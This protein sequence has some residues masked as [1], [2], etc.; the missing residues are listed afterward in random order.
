MFWKPSDNQ[1]CGSQ[2]HVHDKKRNT[3]G[4]F[5]FQGYIDIFFFVIQGVVMAECVR[6]GQ[7][8]NQH[9]YIEI[10]TKLLERV[11]TKRQELW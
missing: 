2:H 6:K 10:V 8:V 1:Y 7:T 5:E 3:H 9:Y 4:S 11:R